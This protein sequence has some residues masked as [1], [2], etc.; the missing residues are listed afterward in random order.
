VQEIIADNLLA[1]PVGVGAVSQRL[2]PTDKR[3][4]LLMHAATTERDSSSPPT[5]NWERF[6]NFNESRANALTPDEI[7]KAIAVATEIFYNTVN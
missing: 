6:S 4:S 2:I 7:Q 5:K 3:S 1:K